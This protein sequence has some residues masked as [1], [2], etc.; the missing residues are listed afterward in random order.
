MFAPNG[1]RVLAGLGL[2]N[3]IFESDKFVEV[4]WLHI[5]DSNGSLLGKVPGGSKERFEYTS[6]MILRMTIL[7]ILHEDAEKRG[8]EVRFGAKVKSLEESDDGVVVGWTENGEE[9]ES[10]ADL[11]V[12]ADGIWSVVRKR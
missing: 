8:I 9:K 2:G 4:P 7:E 3:K 12:G 1:M 5:Y 10:K 11:V 6:I